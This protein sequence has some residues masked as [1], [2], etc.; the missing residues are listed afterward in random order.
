MVSMLAFARGLSLRMILSATISFLYL[1][2][3]IILNGRSLSVSMC[4]V[5]S[6][7]AKFS[8]VNPDDKIGI[9]IGPILKGNW[10]RSPV[11]NFSDFCGPL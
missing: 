8:G 11:E 3:L 5:F 4:R 9:C 7:K 10:L 1:L 6:R 2:N